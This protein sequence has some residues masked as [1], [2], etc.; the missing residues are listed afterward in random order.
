[1]HHSSCRV[2]NGL[3][4]E[5]F[6]MLEETENIDTDQNSDSVDFDSM[7]TIKQGIKFP[8]SDDQWKTTNVY[9]A[10]ALPI[11]EIDHRNRILK[12]WPNA[13]NF[14]LYNARQAC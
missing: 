14:S 4:D 2:I 1:M 3:T 6:D 8:R 5:T 9:F 12:P 7:P 10:A 11:S 13:L